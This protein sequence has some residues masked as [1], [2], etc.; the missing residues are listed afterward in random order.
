MGIGLAF[1]VVRVADASGQLTTIYHNPDQN[2]ADARFINNGQQIAILL[3][4]V[5]DESNPGAPIEQRWVAVDR[6]GGVTDLVT[7]LNFSYLDGAPD[8][9]V[10]LIWDSPNQ[11]PN[12]STYRLLYVANGQT[13]ELWS[14]AGS[15]DQ[16]GAW[17]L[18]WAAPMPAAE[19]LLP[20]TPI[21]S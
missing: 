14:M 4:P 20:F 10:H 15:A 8:G 21:V 2:P 19:G 3:A 6:A 5:F 1:N 7:D 13:T 12:N 17:E 9:F 16:Y 11:D 18:A